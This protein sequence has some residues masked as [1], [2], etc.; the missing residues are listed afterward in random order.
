MSKRLYYVET[1]FGCCLR[2]A[3]SA[4][5]VKAYEADVFRSARL[6]TT[7]DQ[8]WVLRMGGIIETVD[9]E[10]AADEAA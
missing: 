10:L 8:E 1:D 4:D 5:A 9:T 7:N 6:A 2:F 3:D